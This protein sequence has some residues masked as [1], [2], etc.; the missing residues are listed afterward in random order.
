MTDH[1]ELSGKFAVHPF[2]F[3]QDTD[4]AI[5][6]SNFVTAGKGWVDTSVGNVLRIRN[7][8]NTAWVVSIAG[9]GGVGNQ[10][11]SKSPSIYTLGVFPESNIQITPTAVDYI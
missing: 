8:A 2:A 3:V 1:H 9:S 7:A 5:E 10:M 11:V 6:A 4:P